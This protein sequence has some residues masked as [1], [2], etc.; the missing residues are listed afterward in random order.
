MRKDGAALEHAGNDLRKDREVV[1]AA[2]AECGL[3]LEH[4]RSV[5][6]DDRGVV[7]EA[8]RRHG[9]A[10]HFASEGLRR[11]R[12]I[13]CL[14]C[15]NDPLALEAVD[16]GDPALVRAAQLAGLQGATGRLRGEWEEDR[17]P[18]E[19]A[20]RLRDERERQRRELREPQAQRA[21]QPGEPATPPL[22]DAQLAERINAWADQ[23]AEGGKLYRK[24]EGFRGHNFGKIAATG[25][26]DLG[27]PWERPA[28]RRLPAAS[29]ASP[30]E[31]PGAVAPAASSASSS[32]PTQPEAAA[33]RVDV[34]PS[35]VRWHLF[36]KAQSLV[37]GDPMDGDTPLMESGI[38]S[39]AGVE[40]R[41]SLHKEYQVQLPSTLM[42][43]YPTVNAMTQHLVGEVE[44]SR[45]PV[46]SGG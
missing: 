23:V 46:P 13:C 16:R 26:M 11:D 34:D 4:A 35:A 33:H 22:R 20:R 45:V 38:D 40:L 15:A 12:E 3:A 30:I 1:L 39:I 6:R 17:A 7:L 44:K 31:V 37:L 10:L 8:V 9:G 5:L 25:Q 24:I 19:A 29:A 21:P 36:G 2:I 28:P 27:D 42:F 41:D 43:D 32:E 14:A 18:A